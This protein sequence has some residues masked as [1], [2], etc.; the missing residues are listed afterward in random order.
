MPEHIRALV[1]ILVIAIFTFYF[2]KKAAK[3]FISTQQFNHWRNAWFAITLVAFLAGNFWIFVIVSTLCILY[4]TKREQNPFALFVILLFAA[5]R[6]SEDIPGFGLVNFLFSLDYVRLLSLTILLP[7]YLHLRKKPSALAFGKN[8]PDKLL[9]TYMV[10][11]VALLMRDTS[12]TDMLRGALYNFT[13]IFLPYYVASRGIKNYQQLK[14]VIVAFTIAGLMAGAIAVFEYGKFW[15]LYSTLADAWQIKW[16][17]GSYLGR[18]DNLRAMASLGQPIVL[19]Y[20]MA[21]TLGFYLF[22][23]KSI[24]SRTLRTLGLLLILAGLYAPLSRGPWV[25]AAA[26]VIVFI[27]TGPYAIKRL[28]MLGLAMLVSLPLLGVIPGG[29]KIINLLPFV[30][31]TEK[32]N[33]DYR[34]KLLDNAIIV[35]KRYPIFGSVKYRDELA[36][37]EMVQGEGIVDVVNSYLDVVLKDGIVGLILFIGFFWLVLLS[38]YKKMKRISDKKSQPYLFGRTLISC[39]IGILVTIF[40]VSSIL[41]IPIIYWAVA[42]LGIAYARLLSS[43]ET[44]ESSSEAGNTALPTSRLALKS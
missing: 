19:G 26:I 41:L 21:I 2:S 15:L 28:S 42:G 17:M 38:I 22:M 18:G 23:A 27:A 29:Q 20:V 34:V 33:I 3:P 37:L 32:E 7:A 5:P 4:F 39:Q 35:F 13:D 24:K 10:L 25:G 43:P 30:G 36:N 31:T 40:T 12:F 14:E 11:T 16:S 8:W 9:L 1:V 6:I 44:A